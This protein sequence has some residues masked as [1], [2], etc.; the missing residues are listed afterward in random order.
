MHFFKKSSYPSSEEYKFLYFYLIII[1]LISNQR[2]K[3]LN[4]KPK[5]VKNWFSY[6][7]KLEKKTRK[8]GQPLQITTENLSSTNGFSTT[9]LS[10]NNQ[11]V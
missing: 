1:L 7:R 6:R 5:N 8:N 10:I 4:S 9:P 3:K 2:A 11:I